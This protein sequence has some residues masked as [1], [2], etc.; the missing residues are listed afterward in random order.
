MRSFTSDLFGLESN[1]LLSASELLLKS[2][3]TAILGRGNRS[4][5]QCH[6]KTG[7]SEMVA[8]P[9]SFTCQTEIKD[10]CTI[11]EAIGFQLAAVFLLQK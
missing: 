9:L 11:K 4:D 8:A 10:T 7:V 3:L 5:H 1:L 6:E 2:T